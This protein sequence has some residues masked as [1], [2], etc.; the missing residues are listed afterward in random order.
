MFKPTSSRSLFSR[1]N[2]SLLWSSFVGLK[3][4]SDGSGTEP[5]LNNKPELSEDGL[6]DEIIPRRAKLQGTLDN[7]V[8][9]LVIEQRNT[10]R[11]QAC[12]NNVLLQWR[13][14]NVDHLLSRPGTVLVDTHLGQVR[15]DF[16]Q[17]GGLD[18]VGR[19]FKEFLNNCVP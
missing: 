17:H 10:V 2:S 15:R 4:S 5:V 12:G 14:G 6:K 1:D 18:R 9:V 7:I 11:P 8:T 13:I 19:K 3:T 16:L